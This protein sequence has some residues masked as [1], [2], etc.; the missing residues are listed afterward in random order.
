MRTSREATGP[1]QRIGLLLLS[2]AMLGLAA[3]GGEGGTAA[4][5]L[6]V[7]NEVATIVSPVSGG[8]ALVTVSEEITVSVPAGIPDIELRSTLGSWAASGT[9]T[10]TWTALSGPITVSGSLSSISQGTATIEVVDSNSGLVTD[11]IELSFVA[12]EVDANSVVTVQATP[13]T[14]GVSTATT[15]SS[16][17]IEA[18]VTNASGGVLAD[19]Q[20]NFTLSNTTGSGEYILPQVAYTNAQGVATAT[21]YAGTQTTSGSGLTVTASLDEALTGSPVTYST[22]VMVVGSRGS[23][24]IGTGVTVASINADTGYSL[25]VVVF[26][27]DSVGNPVPGVEVTLD[28]WP[29]EYGLGVWECVPLPGLFGK[30][31]LP[32][33]DQDRDSILDLLPVSEDMSG[34][35]KLTPSIADGGVIPATVTTNESGFAQFNLTYPKPSAGFIRDEI[36]ASVTVNGVEVTASL[37]FWL[38]ALADDVT[39]C[40]LGV[41]PFNAAW[42]NVSAVASLTTVTVGGSTDINV[43]LTDSSGALLAGQEI[44]AEFVQWGSSGTTPPTLTSSPQIT[45]ASGATSFTIQRVTKWAWM[46]SGSTMYPRAST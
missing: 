39:S 42:P 20:V 10:Q 7:E 46:R 16:S 2:M 17:V 34:D 11:S 28:L 25:P 35:G 41:S 31:V 36:A 27:N 40:S 12:E 4:V 29:L 38:P 43:T 3:C 44:Y 24:S 6:P 9:N 33:E 22:D 26:V 13:A 1:Y 8:T 32:N 5:P 45:D 23:V 14:I 15:E 18:L 19:A 21:L 37:R 30:T